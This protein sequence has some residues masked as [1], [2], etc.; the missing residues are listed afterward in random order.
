MRVLIADDQPSVGST[1][2]LLVSAAK[3]HV[4]KVV[5]SG[6]EAIRAYHTYKP[7]IVLMD[8]SMARLNGGTACRYILTED[9]GARIV[10]VSSR[11]ASELVNIGAVAILPKPVD[12]KELEELLNDMDA[13]LVFDYARAR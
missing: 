2:A 13:Q 1:L 9:P 5:C 4:V 10:F 12:L 6:A 7:D 11:P 3:H 8:Y